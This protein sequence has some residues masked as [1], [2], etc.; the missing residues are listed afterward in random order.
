MTLEELDTP[1]LVVDTGVMQRNLR[2]MADYA[3]AYGLRLRPHTK[4]HKIPA[5]GR[6][7][8]DL[9]AVGLTVAKPG[10]A[11]VML[12]AEPAELLVA[13]PTV[14]ATKLR[15]L[16]DVAKRTRLMMSLDS[17]HVAEPLA[18]A[19]SEAGVTIGVLA[20]IDVGLGRVGVAP[21]PA[22][23]AL[24]EFVDRAP[25]LE[26]LGL[27]FYPGHVKSLDETGIAALKQVAALLQETISRLRARG[28]EAQIVSGGSTP[29]WE[30]SHEL[31]G[32]TEIRPGTYIFNDR[33]SVAIGSC[34]WE[35]CAASIIATVVSVAK[36]GQAIIDGGSKT[37]SSDRLA[38]GGE[39]FGAVL[40]HPEVVF[41]KMNEEHG[42][43]DLT[44]SGWSPK[45]GDR[46]QIVPNHICVAVNL[47]ETLYG[48]VDGRVTSQ[49]T[50]DGRGKLQ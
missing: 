3:G 18:Q 31:A 11:E 13:Y 35:D 44:K 40:G 25:G 17:I 21:G 24:V 5:L 50:V 32:M 10:E 4:T 48:A 14:G 28:L 42:F 39:G 43:L 23:D 22:L 19:A 47:H 29:S 9:G 12:A 27:A 15:R 34:A 49:W 16:M 2:R 8:L 37:F 41:T 30:H 7:Q 33:N 20:E 6:M 26:W 1:A 45:V 36:P 38:M 46:V